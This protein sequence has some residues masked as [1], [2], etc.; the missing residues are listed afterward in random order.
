MIIKELYK[1]CENTNA[2]TVFEIH[3]RGVFIGKYLYTDYNLTYVNKPI[4]SFKLTVYDN[5][6]IVQVYYW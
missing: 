1:L 6:N 4:L 3:D 2:H 5:R